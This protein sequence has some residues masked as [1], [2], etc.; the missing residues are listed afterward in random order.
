MEF[1]T[2]NVNASTVAIVKSF[3]RDLPICNPP[4]RGRL[5]FLRQSIRTRMQIMRPIRSLCA[6]AIVALVTLLLAGCFG[7]TKNIF[8][9]RASIQQ[10]TVQADGSWRVQLRLQNYSNV[11]TTF[12]TVDAKIEMAG[13]PA[14]SV[15]ASP[16]MRIGP[17]S[18]DVIDVSLVPAPAAAQAI[19][20]AHAGNLRYRIAGRI[21][22]T[23]PQG[24]YQYTFE[25]VLSPVPGLNG[26]LR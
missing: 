14:G 11:S 24:D 13:N 18:A 3:S 23:D 2:S 10:I 22:T 17:E 1:A 16:A 9:P 7:E 20:A 26:V 8:P 12:G 21:T 19:A 25:S 5:L 6:F 4:L 15:S